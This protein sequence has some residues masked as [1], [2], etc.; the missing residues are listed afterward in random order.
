MKK[1][2]IELVWILLL[3]SMLSATAVYVCLGDF[4]RA[5]YFLIAYTVFVLSERLKEINKT[6]NY[7]WYFISLGVKKND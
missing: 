2:I 4:T 5:S 7:V 1:K 3:V 6:L